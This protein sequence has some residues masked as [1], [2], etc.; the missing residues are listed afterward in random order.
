MDKIVI[1]DFS[2]QE[3]DKGNQEHKSVMLFLSNQQDFIYIGDLSILEDELRIA[4][5]K[6]EK[7]FYI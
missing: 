6:G 1:G 5:E 7:M 3:Y 4:K 2:I